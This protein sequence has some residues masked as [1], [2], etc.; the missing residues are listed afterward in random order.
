MTIPKAAK[1]TTKSKTL[2]NSC[3]GEVIGKLSRASFI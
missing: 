2:E 1:D 3:E